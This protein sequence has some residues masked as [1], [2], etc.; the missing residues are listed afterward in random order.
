MSL[1]KPNITKTSPA[2]RKKLERASALA[3]PT[4]PTARG[5]TADQIKAALWIPIFGSDVSLLKELDRVVDAVNSYLLHLYTFLE[6]GVP[7]TGGGGSDTESVKKHNTDPASHADIRIMIQEIFNRLQAIADSDDISLDQLSEIVA[8]IKDNKTLIERI[9]TEKVNVTDIIDN[10]E[11][12]LSN[13]PLSAKQ[14][15]VLQ[16]QITDLE[17]DKLNASELDPAIA[18]A[19]LRANEAISQHN[20][21]DDAH[22]DIRLALRTLSNQ[23]QTIADSDDDTLNQMSEIVAVIKNNKS[24]IENITT[25]KVN[26][27]DIIDNLITSATNKPLSAKQGVVLKGLI[28]AL[29]TNKLNASALEPAIAQVLLDAQAQVN[30]HNINEESHADLRL[31]ISDYYAVVKSL[32]DSDDETLNQTSEIVGYIKSNRSLIDAITTSKVNVLDIVDNLTTNASN[33]PL[34][35]KQGVALKGMFDQLSADKLSIAALSAAITQ[36]LTE[37]KNSGAFDGKDGD[38]GKTPVKGVDYWTPE[39]KEAIKADNIAYIA[40]ELAKR[41]QLKPEFANSIEE[42]TDTSKLYVL[43]D[44]YIYAYLYTE[45]T[46]EPTN[47]IPKST[48]TDRKTIY[49]GKG[50][51]LG[52]RI[53]SSGAV[54]SSNAP[55]TM[56]VTGFIPAKL[57]DKITVSNYKPNTSYTSYV[58]AYDSS[59]ACTGKLAKDGATPS[60]FSVTLDSATFGTGFNAIRI[61]GDLTD[62]TVVINESNGGTTSGYVWKN[63]GLAFVPADYEDRIVELEA[64]VET[65][66]ERLKNTGLAQ[67]AVSEVFAP[68][69]QLPADGSETA[70]FNGDW[71]HITAEQIYAYIDAL[72]NKYSRFITKEVMGKDES[73]T[74]DWCRY[75]CSRR[76]YDAWQKPNYPPMYAWVN[77]STVI[78]S[79]SVS[80]RIGDTLYTTKY[81][82]TAKGTVTAVSNANQ[83]RTVGGVVY[84]RDKTKDVEPTLVYTETAYSPYF[85]SNYVGYKNGVYDGSKAKISTISTLANGTLTGAN[86]VSYTRYPLGD[87]NSKFEEIPAIVIGGNEHGTGGDPATP[88]MV[89][90]RMVKD[91]CECKNA[92]NPF[93]NL[94]KNEYMM[95]FCPVVNPWGLH[96]NNK[97][98]TNAN[99][100]NLDRNFDTPG[101]HPQSEEKDGWFTGNY[102]GSENETQYFMNTLVASKCKLAMCN[103]SYGQG[104]DSTTGEAVSAGICSY[105]LGAD[106]PKYTES[107]LKIAEVMA[108]NYNLLFNKNSDTATPTTSAKTR[109]Y[110]EWIGVDGVALEMN[111]RDGFITDPKNEAKG[112]QFT[113]RVMEAAYTQLLQVLYMMISKQ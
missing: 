7:G 37:A 31:L 112:K 81:V 100:V 48:D 20:T 54:T 38:P 5:M 102:G 104:L 87:R 53:N 6:N 76:A 9:T 34:S 61:T 84:T 39:D 89:S 64:E 105:M 72:L 14:G 97:S 67:L 24:L 90:A 57:G 45:I 50:Y 47:E 19:L 65:L 12:N 74:H 113:A 52:L 110:I 15:V 83:S 107:L 43:P 101:W 8:F 86:G 62:S 25:S 80:P 95:V 98:Y 13:K 91:L 69:P 28:D 96:K 35:A 32:L 36:A 40:S 58:A 4:N 93:I 88:A 1:Y 71:N 59:N 108:A 77:G 17:K 78:Y 3:L 82:G 68:S 18:D 26:V 92:D 49:N 22:A 79:V 66:N 56:G 103:H 16:K 75:I 111:S 2:D 109:S 42:C 21:S 46:V 60:S 99:E 27:S 29:T 30:A 85:S 51:Q 73:G 10:V 44:G 70:D 41:G 23:L 94:L 55:A 106:K 33:K 63:T 11:T